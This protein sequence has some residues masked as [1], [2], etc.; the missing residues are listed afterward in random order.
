MINFK[1]IF[2]GVMAAA[3][4]V[5]LAACSNSGTSTTASTGSD[6]STTSTETTIDDEID[7]PVSVGDISID[8]G[9]EVEPA[10]LQY[11]GCYDITTAGDVK[12]AYKY[13]SE[14]YGCTIKCTIVGSLQILEKLTTA[15]SAGE[16]PDLVDY[17]DSTFPL[18]MSKN[19]YTPL[20]EYIDLSAPQW[21][22]LDQYINKYKWTVRITTTPGLITFHPTSIYL[23]QRSI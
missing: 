17:S 15:I 5:S 14:H 6:D 19:M 22:G 10:E 18:M 2:A 20:D 12:P 11:L 16:S 3:T 1:R 7:N 4:A 8:A 23:Q 13:F 9:E 21:S